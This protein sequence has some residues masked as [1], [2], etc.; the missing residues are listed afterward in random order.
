MKSLI[1][2][3][4]VSFSLL[5]P[6]AYAADDVSTPLASGTRI[7]LTDCSMLQDDVTPSLSAGVLGAYKCTPATNTIAVATCHTAGRTASRSIDVPCVQT[8]S[9]PAVEGEVQC[10]APNTTVNRSTSTG[11]AIYVGR[12]SGGAIGPVALDGSQCLQATINGKI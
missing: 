4:V 1:A 3:V 5:A 12:T 10:A 8:L 2:S 6:V 7:V 11:A 9:D